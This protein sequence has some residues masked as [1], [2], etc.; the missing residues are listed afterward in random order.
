MI[1]NFK[2]PTCYYA[3]SY[4]EINALINTSQETLNLFD[5]CVAGPEPIER[6]NKIIFYYFHPQIFFKKLI[7]IY[8]SLLTYY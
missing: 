2:N 1:K 6:P 3:I 8:P 4:I 7:T 5:K